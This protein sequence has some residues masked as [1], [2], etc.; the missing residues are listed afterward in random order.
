MAQRV[1]PHMRLIYSLFVLSFFVFCTGCTQETGSLS[2]QWNEKG[3]K[4]IEQERYQEAFDAYNTALE[5]DPN[6]AI[7]Y[8]YRGTAQQYLGKTTEA[9]QDFDNATTLD[10]N[11]RRAWTAK[12]LLYIE[13]ENYTQAERAATRAIEVTQTSSNKAFADA[14]LVRGFVQNRLE[15]YES[16]LRDFD[17][18]ITFE[19]E[20]KDLWEHKAYSLTNLG[21]LQEALQC[22]D[23]LLQLYPKDPHIWNDKGGVHMALGQTN[24]ANRAYAT[25]KS[26]MLNS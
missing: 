16:A 11:E 15:K 3:N 7:T 19:P 21:R 26:I 25:A 5:Y 17:M 18:A 23:Y 2:D 1:F 24:E 14:Y 6:S 10:P 8:M 9:M 12:A 13:F 4:L 20:R 22:Y